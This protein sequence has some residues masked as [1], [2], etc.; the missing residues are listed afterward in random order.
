MGV[1]LWKVITYLRS[2]MGQPYSPEGHY[3][4]T[5]RVKQL[6]DA[7]PLAPAF[8]AAATL[9]PSQDTAPTGNALRA[10]VLLSLFLTDRGRP[11]ATR[12]AEA[13]E[14]YERLRETELVQVVNRNL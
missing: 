12:A 7:N 9:S 1:N 13:F 10:A 14:R 3:C 6:S 4:V 2:K 8:E 5:L 11:V